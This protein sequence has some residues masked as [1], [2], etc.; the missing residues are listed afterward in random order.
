MGVAGVEARCWCLSW[1][2]G[3]HGGCREAPV[4]S[5][6]SGLG[7][8][9]AAIGGVCIGVHLAEVGFWPCF[10]ADVEGNG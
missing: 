2:S 5:A 7:L 9:A 1:P 3:T 4:R 10:Y 6:G 8:T